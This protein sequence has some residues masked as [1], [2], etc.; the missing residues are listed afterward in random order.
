MKKILALFLCLFFISKYCS[1]QIPQQLPYQAILMQDGEPV[2]DTDVT[3]DVKILDASRVSVFSETHNTKTDTYGVAVVAIGSAGGDLSS[4]PW[5]QGGLS[6]DLSYST[7]DGNNPLGSQD[8]GSVPYAFYA[9]NFDG[10]SSIKVDE[11]GNLV[12]TDGEGNEETLTGV[13]GGLDVTFEVDENGNLIVVNP[14]GS[15]TNLGNVQGP[16]GEKG[17]KGDEGAKGDKGDPGPKGDKGDTGDTGPQG[18]TGTGVLAYGNWNPDQGAI[19]RSSNLSM[20]TV[21]GSSEIVITVAGFSM[22]Q[23]NCT[24]IVTSGNGS[25]PSYYFSNGSIRVN[26]TG[27]FNISIFR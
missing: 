8:M 15:K 26:P 12:V 1:A 17:T 9:M 20:A 6:I 4:V 19:F 16:T 14:D 10:V 18:T 5:S 11:N 21:S 27:N 23:S 25:V 13:G 7:G 3:I 24:P 22:T 2:A